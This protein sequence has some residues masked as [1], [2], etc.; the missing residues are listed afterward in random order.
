MRSRLLAANGTY[1]NQ[2]IIKN[3]PAAAEVTAANSYELAQMDSWL[4]ATNGDHASRSLQQ[5][6]I[7]DKPAGLTDGCYVSAT[8]LISQNLTDPSGGQC[9]A[10]YPVATNPTPFAL[11]RLVAR[12]RGLVGWPQAPAW[13]GAGPACNGY[14]PAC[15]F[16]SAAMSNLVIASI[17]SV[18]RLAFSGSGSLIISMSTVG[19]TCQDSPYLSFSQ[20]HATS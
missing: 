17:A 5:K 15:A 9:G 14:S 16:R 8:E 12:C 18:A 11:A 7:A 1:G 20:P 6:V 2:V 4:T 13:C 10:L 3:Q 19:M